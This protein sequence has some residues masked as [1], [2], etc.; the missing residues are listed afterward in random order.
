[1]KRQAKRVRKARTAPPFPLVKARTGRYTAATTDAALELRQKNLALW[2]KLPTQLR[3]EAESAERLSQEWAKR[4]PMQIV[5]VGSWENL[6]PKTTELIRRYD[7][8]GNAPF[9]DALVLNQYPELLKVPGH[10]G[11]WPKRETAQL[12]R[13]VREL[14]ADGMSQH[15]ISSK[16]GL[17][18]H[19]LRSLIQHYRLK[20]R[21]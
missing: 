19:A 18:Y 8:V 3:R 14:L 4:G 13:T 5:G 10:K 9:P 2:R 16:L 6:H 11:R 15:Q 20:P 7:K 1:M 17:E 12:V 21:T